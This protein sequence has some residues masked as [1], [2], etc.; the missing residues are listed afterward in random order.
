MDH[1]TV[2]TIDTLINFE[3]MAEAIGKTA[4]RTVR[5]L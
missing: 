5:Q 2:D 4:C 1:L 3:T